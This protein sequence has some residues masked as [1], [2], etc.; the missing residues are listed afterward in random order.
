MSLQVCPNCSLPVTH[1]KFTWMPPA[2]LSM[3]PLICSLSTPRVCRV[4][5]VCYSKLTAYAFYPWSFKWDYYLCISLLL[6]DQIP[7]EIAVD[8]Q[9]YP[10]RNNHLLEN[11]SPDK[12]YLNVA[13]L[14][15]DSSSGLGFILGLPFLQRYYSIY[16]NT[17]QKLGLAPTK[18]TSAIINSVVWWEGTKRLVS[19]PQ[20]IPLDS[21]IYILRLYPIHYTETEICSVN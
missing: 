8:A 20:V 12:I 2:Q 21:S 11:G 5:R 7:F 16:D 15:T 9:V 14:P 17:N 13:S 10:R 3:S 18:Y 1:T 6:F 19:W 4:Y